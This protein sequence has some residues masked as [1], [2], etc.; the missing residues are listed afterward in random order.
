MDYTFFSVGFV[1]QQHLAKFYENV[2]DKNTIFSNA[3]K[4]RLLSIK[5]F[6]HNP[7]SYSVCGWCQASKF[8]FC[9][10]KVVLNLLIPAF[11]C[12]CRN[13]T[14]VSSYCIVIQQ[15]S[16]LQFSFSHVSVDSTIYILLLIISSIPSINNVITLGSFTG[17]FSSV[18]NI[19]SD[20]FVPAC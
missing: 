16:C 19:I 12:K 2:F 20:V 3:Y 14:F 1:S 6:E 13:F 8:L 17:F 7:L 18:I 4:L 15:K 10:S 5:M 9:L 11:Y